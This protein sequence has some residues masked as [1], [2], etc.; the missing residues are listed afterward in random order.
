LVDVSKIRE[1]ILCSAGNCQGALLEENAGPPAVG[2]SSMPSG[3]IADG[4]RLS[5]ATRGATSVG[6]AGGPPAAR[7]PERSQPDATARD[8]SGALHDPF[9]EPSSSIL[10]VSQKEN[11]LMA[12]SF[13]KL[14]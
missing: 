6:E 13:I 8:P 2:E 7:I 10:E 4:R 3:L 14:K 5:T 11:R 9:S 12:A 1:T